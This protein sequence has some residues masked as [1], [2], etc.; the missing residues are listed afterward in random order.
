MTKLRVD[1]KNGFLEVEGEESFVKEIYGDYKDVLSLILSRQNVEPVSQLPAPAETQDEVRPPEKTKSVSKRRAS[2]KQKE[3][4]KIVGTLNLEPSGKESFRSFAA[5]KELGSNMVVNLVAVYYLQNI[6]GITGITPDH[7]YTCYK[8]IGHKVPTALIQSLRDTA[9][10]KSW[11]DTAST[12]NITLLTAGE[13]AVEH[14]LVR[15]EK[16]QES[17]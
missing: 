8:N 1:L 11:I 2:S 9:S 3:S 7:V 12:D 13:N 15:K 17:H 10:L 4:H 14:D 5:T 16:S 6:L